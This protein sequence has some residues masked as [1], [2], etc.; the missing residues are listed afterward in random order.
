MSDQLLVISSVIQ[1]ASTL[2]LVFITWRYAT[3]TKRL[4]DLQ[5][6]P[7]LDFEMPEDILD[8]PGVLAKI[9][10][11]SRCDVDS[12]RLQASCRFRLEDGQPSNILKCIDSQSWNRTLRPREAVEFNIAGYFSVATEILAQQDLTPG[13]EVVRG[14]VLLSVSFRRAADG[15]EFCF[16][17]PYLVVPRDDGRA[18]ISKAGQRQ[19]VS[20]LDRKILKRVFV[21]GAPS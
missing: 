3:F 15:K 11:T 1:G 14:T 12:L 4:V 19:H 13:M 5:I 7:R 10:N 9:V 20:T 16:E 6:E 17:E 18:V 2:L 21:P 8:S